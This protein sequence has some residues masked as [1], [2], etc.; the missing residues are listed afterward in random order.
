MEGRRLDLAETE[1]QTRPYEQAMVK[2]P[3]ASADL[4]GWER[5]EEDIERSIRLQALS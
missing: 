4:G 3:E 5:I 1:A 2:Y